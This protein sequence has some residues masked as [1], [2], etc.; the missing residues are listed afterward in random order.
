M[1]N[2]KRRRRGPLPLQPL[3]PLTEADYLDLDNSDD[4]VVLT[5]PGCDR[6]EHRLEIQGASLAWAQG[7]RWS[8]PSLMDCGCILTISTM[9]DLF[10]RHPSSGSPST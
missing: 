4:L 7:A 5:D 1:T 10:A 8:E 2:S 6:P 3:E 9:A